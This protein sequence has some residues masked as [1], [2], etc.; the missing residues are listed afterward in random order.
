MCALSVTEPADADGHFMGKLAIRYDHLV[1]LYD[2]LPT[3]PNAT[4]TPDSGPALAGLY[5]VSCSVRRR[6]PPPAGC[7][8][9]YLRRDWRRID[10]LA[11]VSAVDAVRRHG[12]V[13]AGALVPRTFLRQPAFSQAGFVPCCCPAPPLHNGAK[14]CPVTCSCARFSA[15][16]EH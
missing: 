11:L 8:P 5:G 12:A 6:H 10:P 2:I 14:F 3:M 13:A 1:R 15:H 7:A 16:Q 4:L 9:A